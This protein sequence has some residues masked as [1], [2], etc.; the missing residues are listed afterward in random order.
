[1]RPRMSASFP[2]R[3]LRF[4]R[5]GGDGLSLTRWARRMPWRALVRPRSLPGLLAVLAL[6]MLTG[7]EFWQGRVVAV[8]DG[9]T[10]VVR[11]GQGNEVRVRLYGIDAPELRQRGGEQARDTLLHMVMERQ[12]YLVT[13]DRDS[14]GRHVAHVRTTPF[15]WMKI[16]AE[17]AVSAGPD[18]SADVNG[19]MVR[20]GQ[21]WF[22]GAYCHL[23]YPCLFW[24]LA[25]G[26]AREVGVG[27]WK[28]RNP[29]PPWEWRR[30]NR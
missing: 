8:P 29:T 28:A 26:E 7:L 30:K 27:L 20:A 5:Q 22:Y 1:M 2:L 10:L 14:Y 3:L 19:D 11:D 9:D 17:G 21:A 25:A 16:D 13:V 6:W 15:P 18:A 4:P 12:A 23:P 24:R